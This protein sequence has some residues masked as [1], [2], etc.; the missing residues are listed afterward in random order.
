MARLAL[1]FELEELARA[2]L[3]ETLAIM[4]TKMS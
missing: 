2:R 1:G 4:F 3:L